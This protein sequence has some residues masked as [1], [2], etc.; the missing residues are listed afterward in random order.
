MAK[1]ILLLLIFISTLIYAETK[2]SKDV[3]EY[4]LQ[5]IEEKYF[6]IEIQNE[7]LIK[8]KIKLESK[9][10]ILENKN[11]ENV[12]VYKKLLENNENMYSNYM[13]SFNIYLLIIAGFF[14]MLSFIGYNNIKSYIH[15][16]FEKTILEKSNKSIEI[17]KNEIDER[18]KLTLE[19]DS[20]KQTLNDK[21][22]LDMITKELENKK[23]SEKTSSDWFLTGLEYQNNNQLD[24]A[25]ESYEKSIKLN[26]KSNGSYYNM[27]IAYNNKG[28]YDKAIESY[29]NALKIN[30]NHSRSYYNM[31]ISYGK[32]KQ[33]D[34]AID[35]Y[36]NSI[37][38]DSDKEEAYINLFEIAL[39][40][41]A[42]L[43]K[44]I[45]TI[46]LEKF[47]NHLNYFIIYEML[48]I[49]EI[50][51]NNGNGNGKLEQWKNKY[52]NIAIDWGF[53]ELETWITKEEN[54]E[55]KKNLLV[56]LEFF[57]NHQNKVQEDQK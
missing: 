48:E 36:K 35:A 6:A 44:G 19:K 31:G 10:G 30:K 21:K 5:Q 45:K 4:R 54:L 29:K 40:S 57:K 47:Q 26:S 14:A 32:N 37:L 12:E 25:I 15:E 2:P 39:I 28:L 3:Y 13:N 8:Q 53:K 27:G 23:D 1:K 55:I 34:E 50:I 22:I 9:I 42:V 56:K 43:D 49:F 11:K 52:T 18:L 7:M 46:Y 33:Y 51:K 20:S 41:N 17:M 24:N 38:I 16:I